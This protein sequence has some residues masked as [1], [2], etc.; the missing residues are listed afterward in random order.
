MNSGSPA[1][2]DGSY[3]QELLKKKYEKKSDN[4]LGLVTG[5]QSVESSGNFVLPD[6][7]SALAG[8]QV[9]Q[10]P[11]KGMGNDRNDDRGSP[12]MTK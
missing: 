10:N 1:Q 6:L 4:P 3:F 8:L 12:I 5:P 9:A 2:K 7:N 11:N